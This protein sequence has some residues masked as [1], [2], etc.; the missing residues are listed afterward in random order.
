[1][2][3]MHSFRLMFYFSYCYLVN[4][5]W[6]ELIFDAEIGLVAGS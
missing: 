5:F 6:F 2:Q 1:M 4:W 3:W